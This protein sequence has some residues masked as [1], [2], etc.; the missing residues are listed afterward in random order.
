MERHWWSRMWLDAGFMW[1]LRII[2]VH[3]KISF[4]TNLI[5]ENEVGLRCQ[6]PS[7]WE[8]RRELKW[9]LASNTGWCRGFW[10][11]KLREHSTL[12]DRIFSEIKHDRSTAKPNEWRLVKKAFRG[13]IFLSLSN[14]IPKRYFIS[15]QLLGSARRI[16]Y[17]QGDLNFHNFLRHPWPLA[18]AKAKL[19]LKTAKST[20]AYYRH[21]PINP[22]PLDVKSPLPYP[23]TNRSSG[24]WTPQLYRRIPKYRRWSCVAELGCRDCRRFCLQKIRQ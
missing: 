23:C 19:N 9:K 3:L 6:M 22:P 20:E 1:I 11:R 7:S 14:G 13:G 16:S 24:E 15:C 21:T 5:A 10:W 4:S 12:L 2:N 8:K 17:F 18:L